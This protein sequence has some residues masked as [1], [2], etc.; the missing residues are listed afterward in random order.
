VH[1]WEEAHIKA[2]LSYEDRLTLEDL[3]K[4]KQTKEQDESIRKFYIFVLCAYVSG[5]IYFL[6]KLT[7]HFP[8]NDPF[9]AVAIALNSK[10]FWVG[11]IVYMVILFKSKEH[12]KKCKKSD[13]EYNKLREE[14]VDRRV[15]NWYQDYGTKICEEISIYLKEKYDINI[16]Y[17]SK[18]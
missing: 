12:A 10:L 13:E 6:Y 7:R 9:Q 3:L 1:K 15:N 16:A 2:I 18:G 8:I 14:V 5:V 11:L 4:A 17:K